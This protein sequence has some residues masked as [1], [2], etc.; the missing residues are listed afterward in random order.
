[1]TRQSLTLISFDDGIYAEG[2]SLDAE[3]SGLRSSRGADWFVQHERLSG[4]LSDG[5]D[6]IWLN[7]D[8]LELAI[9]PTRGMGVWKGDCDG[10]SLGWNSPVRRPVHPAFVDQNRRGG[11]G[12][13]D[14]FNELICRCG[15]GWSGA[16]GTDT[17]RDDDGRVVSEQFLPLHGR[18]AN[19]P[20]HD[21]R[22]DVD[23][24]GVISVTGIVEEASVFGGRLQLTST[25]STQ[26]GS[27]MFRV[28]DTV[29]NLSA[30]PAEVELLYHCNLGP[31]FLGAGAVFNMAA[32]EMAPRDDR[33]AEDVNDWSV[34][35]APQTDYAE[36]VYFLKPLADAD[37]RALAIL[38]AAKLTEAF[39]VRFDVSSLP[40]FAL[41][42]NTQ[43][44]ADGYVTGLEPATS[45]PCNRSFERQNGRV[46]TLAPGEEIDFELDFEIAENKAAVSRLLDECHAMQTSKMV[47]HSKP[48]SGW[49]PAGV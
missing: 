25:L 45:F 4:G 11:I 34:Y 17:V 27:S 30:Q 20:A 22:C 46:I 48:K 23:D 5:V 9:L 7:N 21:V 43:S 13:L 33:A 1:M 8:R 40:W 39:A 42:K 47:T 2:A 24:D 35:G 6:V 49:S 26:I 37:G 36:Q 15:L 41:W 3:S 28:R 38:S 29:R 16:P 14:G 32:E 18:I 31:P 19:L 44:E 12:W 10:I